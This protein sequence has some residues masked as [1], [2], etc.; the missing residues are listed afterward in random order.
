MFAR[1]ALE[2]RCASK[3]CPTLYRCWSMS[4]CAA[5]YSRLVSCLVVCKCFLVHGFFLDMTG[6][7]LSLIVREDPTGWS[8]RNTWEC[9]SHSIISTLSLKSSYEKEDLVIWHWQSCEK[10]VHG[11][12]CQWGWQRT[13]SL[14][15]IHPVLRQC[16]VQEPSFFPA[17]WVVC[18]IWWLQQTFAKKQ[19]H[20]SMKNKTIIGGRMPRIIPCVF[21]LVWMTLQA[22][23]LMFALHLAHGMQPDLF[24]QNVSLC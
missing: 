5:P 14:R 4:M 23:R 15:I 22:D 7:Q 21:V 20:E 24:Q 3:P 1:M 17:K 19:F 2:L 13:F 6:C 10:L 16:S 12:S 18:A 8:M 11:K 9:L